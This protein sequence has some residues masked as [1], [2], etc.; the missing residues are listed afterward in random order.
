HYPLG[1]AGY[2][3]EKTKEL[4]LETCNVLCAGELSFRNYDT[5]NK[6]HKYK[7]YRSVNEYY[8]SW[9]ISPDTSLEASL[10]WK[11]V[12]CQFSK[13]FAKYHMALCNK[14]PLQW[15]NISD[16]DIKKSIIHIVKDSSELDILLTAYYTS[17]PTFIVNKAIELTDPS[18]LT[19]PIDNVGEKD[20]W[21]QWRRRQKLRQW[22]LVNPGGYAY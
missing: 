17:K 13:E 12:F 10:Y 22:W 1:V 7:D 16:E 21:K 14:I 4:T 19:K 15:K 5:H 9:N 8:K 20:W 2:H 6:W 11:W 18:D 3:D